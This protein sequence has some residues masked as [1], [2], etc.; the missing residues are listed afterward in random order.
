MLKIVL[1]NIEMKCITLK[2]NFITFNI[3]H[4]CN[5]EKKIFLITFK[6]LFL[7]EHS[8]LEVWF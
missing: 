5:V 2:P 4:F 6:C 3:L 1:N 8:D 7:I